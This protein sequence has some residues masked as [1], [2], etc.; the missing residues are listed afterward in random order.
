MAQLIIDRSEVLAAIAEY[1]RKYYGIQV[2]VQDVQWSRH[3][4][5]Q[6]EEMCEVVDGAAINYPALPEQ[7]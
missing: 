6:Y 4:E 1:V 7:G 3:I 2:T 5:G